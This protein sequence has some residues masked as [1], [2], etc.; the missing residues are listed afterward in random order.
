MSFS[1]ILVVVDCMLY[2]NMLQVQ[3]QYSGKYLIDM[4]YLVVCILRVE[5]DV[6][7]SEVC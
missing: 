6:G 4:I 5:L 3:I 1:L 2:T 7:M